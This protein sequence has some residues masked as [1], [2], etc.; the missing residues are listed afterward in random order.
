[1]LIITRMPFPARF[2]CILRTIV[3]GLALLAPFTATAGTTWDGG[4]TNASWGTLANWN[5]DGLPLFDGTE[6]ITIG[7]G[8]AS[9][10]TMT[11]DGTRYIDSLLI[12][13]ISGFT[14]AAGSG[15]TLNL[16]S[17]NITRQDVGG[18]EATQTISA[19]IV[20]GDPIGAAAYG[21]TW[22]IAGS[23]GL[24]V[25]GNISEAGGARG[26][27]FT[28]GR[29]IELRGNNTFS[30]GVT[31]SGATQLRVSSDANLGA[32]SGGIT[33]TN[34]T[35]WA[36]DSFASTRTL[37]LS[38]PAAIHVDAGKILEFG[39]LI[40]GNANLTLGIT[41]PGGTLILS[42]SGSNGSGNTMLV[43]T[44]V[45]SLRGNASLGSGNL[46]FSGGTLELGNG[47]FTRA[48]GTGPGQVDFFQPTGGGFAAWG[49]DRIVNLGGAGA[50][51]TWGT[52]NFLWSTAPLLFGS[53]TANAT[54][55]FQ[56]GINLGTAT[57]TVQV[58]RG[59]GSGPDAELSGIIS[60]SP[61]LNIATNGTEGRLL[62]SNGNNS[63]GGSTNIFGGELWLS[64]NATSGAGNTVL[65][66]GSAPVEL[67]KNSG[68][69]NVSLM[70]AAAITIAR[71][72]IVLS[73]NTGTA[74]LGGVTAHA[75][76]F[77]GAITL[78][79]N[80]TT[81]H[82]LTLRAAEG[83]SVTF[84][85]VIADPAGLTG[86]KGAITK[87]G[88]GT[89]VLSGANTY[90]GTTTVNAGVLS[91]QHSTA[92]GST[93]GG[94]T[95]NSGGELQLQGGVA[96]GPELLMLNGAGVSGN[97]A[98]RNMS[99]NNSW[100]GNIILA[101][102][103]VIQALFGQLTLSGI[104][105]N[106]GNGAD[107]YFDGAGN[108]LVL[109]P[110][111]NNADVIKNG[112]GTLTLQGANTY[113][114]GTFVNGGMLRLTGS[115]NGTAGTA[116]TFNGD[117]TFNFNA[118]P[119][120]A[121]NMGTLTFAAGDGTV[122]STY[123]GS[124][125]TSL[126]F[127]SL[128]PRGV[129]A[130]G[131]FVITGGS[132]G[133][134]NKIVLTGQPSGFI[135]TATFFNGD[136]YAY[137]DPSG[138][139]R[140]I[141]YG[142]DPGTAVSNGGISLSGDHVKANG[143]INSQGTQRFETLHIASNIDYTLGS[144][145]KVTVSGI[146]KTGNEPGGATISGGA[147]LEAD[148]N[149][150]MTIRTSR[151]ND[152]LTIMTPIVANGINAVTKTGAGTLTLSGAN[153]YS[154]GTYVTDGT[155]KIGASERLLNTGSLTVAGGTFDVQNFT[156]TVGTVTLSSGAISGS[157][158][159]TVIGSSYDV[160]S[161]SVSA[162]LAGPASLAKN[163][164]GTV[165]LTGANTYTGTTTVNDGQLVAAA[166]S[167][168]ALGSTSAVIVNADGNLTL[169]ASNQINDAAPVTLGGGTL[170]TGGFSEGTASSAGAGAL[171]LT[172]AGSTIDFG[173]GATGTLAFAIFNPGGNSLTI[174]NWTG[175]PGAI[176]D[177]T[178][179]QLLFATDP[180]PNLSS[181]NFTGYQSGGLAFLLSSG[182]YEVT[183]DFSPVPEMNPAV[184][185]AF[186]ALF[187]V[188]IHRRVV[189][190]KAKQ[191]E[192]VKG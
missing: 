54:V 150:E 57:R 158:T 26:L 91:V 18:T 127:A 139:V 29:W 15:G 25:S 71:N 1:M 183:P 53:T 84:S 48:L 125:N 69:D 116:L 128:G 152:F 86:A 45:L 149:A 192:V 137:V 163:T 36:T 10:L 2:F 87:A 30:G 70:A 38:G 19:G 138:Y 66:S 147:Y 76:I 49:A 122:E 109:G 141:N 13:T 77:S 177:A 178:T 179:D 83:G 50:T 32:S 41:S 145:Q 171:N 176:G 173:T 143:H 98:L 90:A 65:G 154:G 117:G 187:G 172:A 174:D 81:G 191:Q 100:A 112:T 31:L 60:G 94:T 113:T 164:D 79:T 4:G 63:Y 80:T 162:I 21:G 59:T 20:L 148:P 126:T 144:N 153:T 132:N 103:S 7:T 56:N 27:T 157:G 161:G 142:V 35:L 11:L 169:G 33:F 5:P 61:S 105:S 52:S 62:L 114:G 102:S 146:L 182:F 188:L 99:G 155:L 104:L 23:N 82:A 140:A 93:A 34:G 107:F 8:F 185:S 101:S 151:E 73:S 16:R 181:F 129:G 51:V 3:L 68:T 9:G 95:V 120:T 135:D 130:S 131:N 136:D 186:C 165:T 6:A 118:A 106:G 119:G 167:G 159:G 108:T 28:G 47:D 175:T 14:L 12:N 180:T 72:I 184:A 124:G 24:V 43:G 134:T 156:E 78:G 40:S 42:G 121:Q 46:L 74:T 189:R 115:L 97:G 166:T 85:G 110:I 170:S 160:R 190:R 111:I 96:V 39:G 75:A 67:G 58:T 55:D 92:L 89:V 44:T 37:N 123:G 64:A 22:N 133:A 88:N 17:G 168:S